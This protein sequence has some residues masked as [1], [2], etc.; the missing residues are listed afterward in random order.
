MVKKKI[1]I[2]YLLLLSF[3]LFIPFISA[4][5]YSNWTFYDALGLTNYSVFLNGTV[6]LDEWR[7]LD[8]GNIEFYNVTSNATETPRFC[9]NNNTYNSMINFYNL[10]SIYNDFKYDNGTIIDN[11]Q[12]FYNLTISKN[13]CAV[14]FYHTVTLLEGSGGSGR[15]PTSTG[16]PLSLIISTEISGATATFNILASENLSVCS[17]TI[18]S[19]KTENDMSVKGDTAN[20]TFGDL[21]PRDY[22]ARLRC[23]DIR[24]NVNDTE[25]IEFNILATEQMKGF[26]EVLMDKINKL[27][28]AISPTYPYIGTIIFGVFALLLSL[29]LFTGNNRPSKKLLEPSEKRFRFSMALFSVLCVF[30][31]ILLQGMVNNNFECHT[32]TLNSLKDCIIESISSISTYPYILALA[33]LTALIIAEFFNKGISRIIWKKV[34]A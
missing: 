24:G 28:K 3:A 2:N 19:W 25:T 8:S 5:D 29:Y 23:E 14:I 27:G 9:N 18:D 12:T 6:Y 26:T 17:I 31:V 32:N 11:S 20:Y 30:F 22:F 33:I 16:T 21:T 13:Q 4:D 34:N 1:K 7:V 15:G 10:S